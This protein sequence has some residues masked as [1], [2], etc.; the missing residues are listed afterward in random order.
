M[1]G[2]AGATT[3]P[4]LYCPCCCT[5]CA[6]VWWGA[7]IGIVGSIIAGGIFAAIYYLAST[8]LFSVRIFCQQHRQTPDKLSVLLQQQAYTGSSARVASCR[9]S[10]NKGVAPGCSSRARHACSGL[11]R[12][13]GMS[14]QQ[15]H[16]AVAGRF[17]CNNVT[18]INVQH[19]R[20]RE[21]GAT[22]RQLAHVEQHRPL[23]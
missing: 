20:R 5:V 16:K 15:R 4:H 11:Q 18:L 17:A 12:C 7:A 9:P 10:S 1:R 22:V 8:S 6:A 3:S 21:T 23:L 14:Q 19:C 2:S 13:L